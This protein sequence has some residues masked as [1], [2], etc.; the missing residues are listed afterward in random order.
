LS[1]VGDT[2]GRSSVWNPACDFVL[3]RLLAAE[4]ER[5]R[6]GIVAALD[7]IVDLIR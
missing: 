4:R 7:R 2:S 1:E 3:Y 6:R 5:Q